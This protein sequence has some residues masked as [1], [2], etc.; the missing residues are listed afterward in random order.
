M[1]DEAAKK[2][3]DVIDDAELARRSD[4]N[5]GELM[6]VMG[7][8]VGPEG[9]VRWPNAIGSRIDT[10]T[11]ADFFSSVVVP[12][13]VAPP[14][15][16]PGSH[17]V[18]TDADAVAG[19]V[20]DTEFPEIPTMGVRLDDP[21]LNLDG[22]AKSVEEPS[23]EKVAEIN[24]QAYGQTGFTQILTGVKDPR[25][26][27]HGLRDVEE[28]ACV[29]LT[30]SLGDDLGVHFVAT[31]KNYRRRGLASSLVKRLLADGRRRGM[32]SA[33]LQASPDGL[34]VWT[35]LGFRQVGVARPYIRP[36]VVK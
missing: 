1:T 34:P 15:E 6:A 5:F 16:D 26:R 13:G 11:C 10:G 27:A 2:T 31:D 35:R 25:L 22:A 17:Y 12:S 19:R 21:T 7:E 24:E 9:V 36:P 32:R 23:L 29:A 18:W 3:P 20:V 28:F 4:A 33:T 30:F 14:V 8:T